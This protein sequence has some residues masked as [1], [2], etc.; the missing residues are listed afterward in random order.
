[1][2]PFAAHSDLLVLIQPLPLQLFCPAHALDAVAQAVL[3][4]HE[5]MP[6]HFTL[7]I[8]AA[9]ALAA[10]VEPRRMTGTLPKVVL[11]QLMQV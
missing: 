7:A 2:P 9:G 1:M 11:Q 4:L 3:P 6:E 5:L 10:E 8:F